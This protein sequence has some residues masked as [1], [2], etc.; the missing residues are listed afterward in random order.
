MSRLVALS[1]PGDTEDAGVL[2]GSQA[3]EE[4]P[5]LDSASGIDLYARAVNPARLHA[6]LET[7]GAP[8]FVAASGSTLVDSTGA[9]Y[10]DLLCGFGAATLGHRPPAV[11]DVLRR[12][13]SAGGPF[14]TAVG[15]PEAAGELAARLCRCAGAA[16]AKVY[17][18]S[19]GAE[20]IE[21]AMKFAAARTG[22]ARFIRVAGG[23]HGLTTG[24]L[25]L[26]GND[27][28][29]TP[30]PSLESGT[31]DQI[32]MGDL[33]SL[34]DLLRKEHH[35]AIVMEVVQGMAGGRG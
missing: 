30:F 31:V 21:T 4:N 8:T 13:A 19:T 16:L 20:G 11:M 23:F 32:E 34:E 1:S 26:A 10:L 7:V 3:A 12:V 5:S 35:A 25:K 24:A 2:L 18:C 9:E 14:T 6:L 33:G 17:F 27:Y 15:I 28:W 29:R 22:R